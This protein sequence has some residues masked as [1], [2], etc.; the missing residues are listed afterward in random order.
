MWL[1][2]ILNPLCGLHYISVGQSR[3][4]SISPS[5]TQIE[6]EA[7]TPCFFPGGTLTH[8]PRGETEAKLGP[9]PATPVSSPEP[10]LS[11]LQ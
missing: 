4:K 6:F 5:Q 7:T 11:S 8:Q 1:L 9:E 10:I 2:E 3:S